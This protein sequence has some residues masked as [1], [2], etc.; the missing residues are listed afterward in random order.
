MHFDGASSRNAVFHG[1]FHEKVRLEHEKS[2]VLCLLV[3]AL[4]DQE[5]LVD[6]RDY[7]SEEELAAFIP[8]FREEGMIGGRQA[9]AALAAFNG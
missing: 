3:L 2:I 8:A 6:Y 4:P 9:D 7:F 1:I 5:I